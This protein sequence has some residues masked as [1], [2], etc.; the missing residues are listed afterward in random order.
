[1]RVFLV[2]DSEV[3]LD[4]L[5]ATVSE[6]AGAKV[7]AEAGSER[8]AIDGI[9]A[10][11]PDTVILDLTLTSGSGIEVLR[12]TKALLPN[13]RIIVLTNKA[14]P[15]YRRACMALGADAFLDKSREFGI[16]G[17]HL[18][19]FVANGSCTDATGGQHDEQ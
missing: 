16:L 8:D 3:I 11:R 6:V 7:A 10:T 17:Q 12:R 1:M 19:N 2:E 18:R 4:H 15:Q 9:R 14:D 5:R 13:I